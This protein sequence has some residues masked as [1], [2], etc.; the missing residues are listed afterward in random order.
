MDREPPVLPLTAQVEQAPP[1]LPLTAQMDRE[2]S[3]LPLT[4]QMDRE[5][6]VLPLTVQTG[7]VPATPRRPLAIPVEQ[8]APVSRHPLM[9]RTERMARFLA[10]RARC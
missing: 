10:P 6:P 5:P 8:T 3:V 4:A 9:P 7:R 2:P 1:I